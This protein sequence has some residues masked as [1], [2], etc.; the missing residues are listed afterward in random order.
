MSHSFNPQI[1]TQHREKGEEKQK[2]EKF[3]AV[4][5]V[6]KLGLPTNQNYFKE[7]QIHL[8]QICKFQCICIIGLI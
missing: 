2:H 8:W 1:R 6:I 5:V 3:I 7:K 4:L